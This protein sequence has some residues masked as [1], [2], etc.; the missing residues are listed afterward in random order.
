MFLYL[1]SQPV[2]LEGGWWAQSPLKRDTLILPDDSVPQEK[3]AKVVIKAYQRF[4]FARPK[5]RSIA[6]A[7]L[8]AGQRWIEEGDLEMKRRYEEM[9]YRFGERNSYKGKHY[10][11]YY[12]PIPKVDSLIVYVR[13]KERYCSLVMGMDIRMVDDTGRVIEGAGWKVVNVT[14]RQPNTWT[15]GIVYLPDVLVPADEVYFHEKVYGLRFSIGPDG[16]STDSCATFEVG[17][18]Y[19]K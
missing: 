8:I 10:D 18:I 13:S 16:G 4:Y 11:L 14:I 15:R 19:L 3:D 7:T 12:Y 5:Q 9:G 2:E 6:G 17:P 1:L